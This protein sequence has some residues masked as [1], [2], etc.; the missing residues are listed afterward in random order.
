MVNPR[1]TIE[2]SEGQYGFMGE[3]LK[4]EQSPW[5]SE[6]REV[7]V[8]GADGFGRGF[9]R[10]WMEKGERGKGD[11]DESDILGKRDARTPNC[12]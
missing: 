12:N 5:W 4:E 2:V 1:S 9:K 3:G 11:D 8:S 10:E 7:H 6:E